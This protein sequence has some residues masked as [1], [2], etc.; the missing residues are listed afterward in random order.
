MASPKS[1]F[2]SRGLGTCQMLSTGL[3]GAL[4][5]IYAQVLLLCL[6]LFLIVF[7]CFSHSSCAKIVT[8]WIIAMPVLPAA[9][10]TG[11]NSVIYL[12]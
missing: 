11:L 5:C 1:V 7:Y 4:F 9:F 2:V 12:L 6:S 3:L 10:T 8:K